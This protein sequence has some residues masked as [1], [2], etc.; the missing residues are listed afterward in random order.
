M[1]FAEDV[2]GAVGGFAA[3]EGEEGVAVEALGVLQAGDVH[4]GG[5]EVDEGDEL[6]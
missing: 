3:A 6:V 4:E 5:E 2:V 1:V